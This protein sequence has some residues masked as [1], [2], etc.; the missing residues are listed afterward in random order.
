M[1]SL[2]LPYDYDSI[3]HYARNTFSRGTYLD[4]ILPIEVVGVKRP[5]IGQRVRL[6]EGDISQANLLYK[7]YKC[8]RTFQ[9]NAASFTSPN[10]YS[11]ATAP[12]LN[13]ASSDPERCEWRITATHGERIVLNIT[14]LD[15]FKSNNCRSDYLEIRDGYWHKSTI[16]GKFCGTGKINELI[17]STGSRML[18]TYITSSGQ[19]HR[20]GFAASYEGKLVYWF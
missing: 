4:T 10:Y 6:S 17:T 9:D 1:N 20:K 12:N 7:C 16:L 14:H 13:S 5:E 8:G 19:A 11:S 15:I 2:G 18:L 3:M